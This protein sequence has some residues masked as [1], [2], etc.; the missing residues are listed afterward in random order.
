MLRF[1]KDAADAQLHA[2][3]LFVEGGQP[4][5]VFVKIAA[6]AFLHVYFK[7]Y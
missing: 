5:P 4:W 6:Q 3:Y 7:E 1:G 2:A